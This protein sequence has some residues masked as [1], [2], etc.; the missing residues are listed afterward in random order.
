ML[1]MATDGLWDHMS[2]QDPDGQHHMIA[3]YV[4]LA[5]EA[6]LVSDSRFLGD[7]NP[8]T[9]ENKNNSISA[10]IQRKLEKLG[11]LAHG[12]ADREMISGDNNLFTRGFLRYDDVT[13]FIV[14]IE[15]VPQQQH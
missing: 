9:A 4:T 6:D 8:T 10:E 14:M 7:N 13:V 15:G 5:M 2:R 1:V 12:M 11:V 3:D